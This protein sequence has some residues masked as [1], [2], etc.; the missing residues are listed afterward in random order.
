MKIGHKIR[1]GTPSDAVG[2]NEIGNH[3]IEHSVA[4]FKLDPLSLDQREEWMSQFSNNGRLQILVSETKGQISGYACT[5]N[6][7][8]RSAYNTSV[9]TTVYIHPDY[10]GTGLGTQLYIC[11]FERLSKEDLHRAYAGITQPNEASMAL[12]RKFGFQQAGVYKEVGRKF[13][14]YRDV[15]WLEKKL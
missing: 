3:Y 12:H 5:G 4:N 10:H 14:K 7:N 1:L 15:I 9:T 11:L 8:D 13:G 6:F 2:I